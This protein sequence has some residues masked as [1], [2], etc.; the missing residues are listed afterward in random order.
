[1]RISIQN[2]DKKQIE[3]QQVPKNQA[4]YGQKNFFHIEI[5]WKYSPIFATV[6]GIIFFTKNI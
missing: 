2:N 1:M 5:L 6:H 3:F 4:R